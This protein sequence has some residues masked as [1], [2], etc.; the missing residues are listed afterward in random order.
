MRAFL[1]LLGWEASLSIGRGPE[2]D[3]PRQQGDVYASTERADTW[4]HDRRQPVGFS[5][6]EIRPMPN[7]YG[8]PS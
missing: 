5:G 3:A 1:S 6:G 7:P 2:P 4:D 8:K